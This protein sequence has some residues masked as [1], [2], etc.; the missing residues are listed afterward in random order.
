MSE[1]DDKNAEKLENQPEEVRDTNKLV[2]EVDRSPEVES[3]NKQLQEKEAQLKKL[4]E[5]F[6]TTSKQ[7]EEYMTKDKTKDEK[8]TELETKFNEA[9]TQLKEIAQAEFE[10]VKTEKIELLKKANVPE[11]RVNEFVEKVKEPADLDQIDWMLATLADSF[12]KAETARR[13]EAEEEAAKLKEEEEAAKKAEEEAKKLEEEQKEEEEIN[14]PS[15]TPANP[16]KHSTVTTPQ[17]DAKGKWEYTTARE[18]I[19]DLYDKVAS[20]GPD[21]KEAQRLI[22][23]LWE[24]FAG[25]LKKNQSIGF[26][27]SQCPVCQAGIVEGEN[28]PYCEFDPVLFKAKGGELWVTRDSR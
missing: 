2:V 25:T 22:D 16:P 20:G 9:R 1:K 5:D 21:A 28:C 26:A 15:N 4:Q 8:F 19:E 10:K 24:K 11:E 7:L 3:I 14:M 23:G 27:V 17:P 13:K 6:A 18:A 12:V